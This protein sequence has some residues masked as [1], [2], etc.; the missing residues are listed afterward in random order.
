M[1]TISIAAIL[2]GFAVSV[3]GQ[4]TGERPGAN[5][6]IVNHADFVTALVRYHDLGQYGYEIRQ[7]TNSA[8]DYL[9]GLVKDR[10]PGEKLAAVFDIDETALSN[11]SLMLDCGFCSYDAQ[12]ALYPPGKSGCAR[13]HANYQ[14]DPENLPAI[15]PV[16]ELY[17]FAKANGVAVFFVT[18]RPSVQKDWTEKNLRDQGYPPWDG[19]YMKPPGD[20]EPAAEFKPKMRE[21]IT[22]GLHYR[23]VLNIG[24]QAS[25]LAGCCAERVFKLPNPFYLIP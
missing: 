6:E 14:C 11:W 22:N 13:E 3:F 16:R 9:E 21:E 12:L 1:R 23:V 15:V 2:G 19:L 5:I 24:D 4:G 7:V 20:K 17:T 10:R 8:R 18:G 25:D